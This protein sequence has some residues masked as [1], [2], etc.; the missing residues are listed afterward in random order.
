MPLT[1]CWMNNIDD[2]CMPNVNNNDNVVLD[3]AVADEA[4]PAAA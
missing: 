4:P 2:N 3:A 1:S